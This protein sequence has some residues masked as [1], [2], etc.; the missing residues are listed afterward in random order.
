[1][2]ERELYEA[3]GGGRRQTIQGFIY[4]NEEFNYHAERER[5]ALEILVRK[6]DMIRHFLWR[7]RERQEWRQCQELGAWAATSEK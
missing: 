7:V 4:C 6:M 1:M 5:H 3:E 2:G